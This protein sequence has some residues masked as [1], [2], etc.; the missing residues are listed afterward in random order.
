MSGSAE[1]TKYNGE[2][3]SLGFNTNIAINFSSSSDE[4]VDCYLKKVGENYVIFVLGL[5]G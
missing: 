3:Q 1:I 2:K 4:I 5:D